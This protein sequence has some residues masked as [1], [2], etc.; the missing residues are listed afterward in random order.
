MTKKRN[1][2]F[3]LKDVTSLRL[4]FDAARPYVA[5][6]D[7]TNHVYTTWLVKTDGALWTLEARFKVPT[8]VSGIDVIYN[9]DRMK[10]AELLGV[11]IGVHIG[12]PEGGGPTHVGD[13]G[14]LPP[15][16]PFPPGP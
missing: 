7:W 13:N 5:V 9:A 12:V 10:L 2:E 16:Q 8:P 3:A 11:Y 6:I 4:P 14:Y 1:P 15:P